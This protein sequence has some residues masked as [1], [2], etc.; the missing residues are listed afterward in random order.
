MVWSALLIIACLSSHAIAGVKEVA[1]SFDDSPVGSTLHFASSE[2]TKTLIAKLRR[3]QLPP[4]LIFANPCKGKSRQ[5]T[6]G[7]IESYKLGGHYIGNHTCSHPRLDRVGFEKYT[8]DIEKADRLLNPL[9]PDQRF[10]R[11]PNLNEGSDP[12]VRDRVRRWLKKRGYKNAPITGDNEDPTF[13]MKINYAKKLGN[14]IDYSAVR[15]L[16]VDHIVSSLECNN[17]LAIQTI[18]SSPKHVLLLH[19]SDA[20]VMFLDDLIS[21]LKRKGWTFIDPITAYSDPIYQRKPQNTY[22]GF[23]LIAQLAYEKTGKKKKCYNYPKMVQ[24]LN[25]ILKL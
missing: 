24:N 9:F 20:T 19:E 8:Q 15:G 17:S 12:K 6:I 22:S 5:D 25:R 3:L 2:R 23:G 16:F 1:L 7:Q 18:G 13:S 14:D 10:F 11:Y 21:E 4:A